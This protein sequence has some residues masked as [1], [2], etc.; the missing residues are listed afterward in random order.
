MEG[1]LL[2]NEF[3]ES[4]AWFSL[5]LDQIKLH[6]VYELLQEILEHF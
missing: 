6:K 2:M 1:G 5:H 3:L 4:I